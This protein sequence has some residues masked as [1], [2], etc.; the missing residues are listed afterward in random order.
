MLN[1]ETG[2]QRKNADKSANALATSQIEVVTYI[3]DMASELQAMAN[4]SG[5]ATLAYLLSIALLGAEEIAEQLRK[6]GS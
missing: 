3:R 6:T 1:S 5:L 4:K 2:V